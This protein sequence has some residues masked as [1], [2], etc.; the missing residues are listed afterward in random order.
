MPSTVREIRL[1][2]QGTLLSVGCGG[3]NSR[4]DA[5]KIHVIDFEVG[6]REFFSFFLKN[7][8]EVFRV[9]YCHDKNVLLGWLEGLRNIFGL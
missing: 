5:A 8:L 6:K 9:Q 1:N 2:A 3:G 4:G 7:S